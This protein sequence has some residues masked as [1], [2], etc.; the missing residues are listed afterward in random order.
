MKLAC[1]SGA[2]H[3]EIESGELTQ[4]EFLDLCARELAC[5]GI[6]LDVRHF[7]RTDDDYLAQV[8]KMATDWGLSIAAVSD[9]SFFRSDDE[10]VTQ[11]LTHAAFLGAPLVAAPLALQTECS[12]SAQLER[13]SYATSLAKRLN[14]TLALRNAPQTFAAGTADCKRVVKETDSAW[15]RYGP[16]PQELDAASDA[17]AL[18][19]NTVL[20]WSGLQRQTEQTVAAAA[21]VFAEFRGYVA[22]DEASGTATRDR[23]AAA[24]ALWRDVLCAQYKELNHK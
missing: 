12:W 9:S 23:L 19:P 16:D 10:H 4:L 14:V 18:A 11:V 5:D 2:L 6:V 24:L 8:K 22:I 21:K 3:R 15:L 17:G 1:A 7:P 20:L 13:L